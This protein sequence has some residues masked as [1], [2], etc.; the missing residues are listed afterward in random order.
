LGANTGIFFSPIEGSN[1]HQQYRTAIQFDTLVSTTSIS[2]AAIIIQYMMCHASILHDNSIE[3]LVAEI[4]RRPETNKTHGSGP[5]TTEPNKRTVRANDMILC[6][7]LKSFSSGTAG[8][9]TPRGLA[10][11][12]DQTLRSAHAD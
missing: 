10:M 2:S 11:S 1:Q 3:L 6:R 7:L 4:F 9:S 8:S 12:L 5:V